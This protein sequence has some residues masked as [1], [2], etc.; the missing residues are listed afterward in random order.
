MSPELFPQ[1]RESLAGAALH[2]RAHPLR[3]LCEGDLKAL[4]YSELSLRIDGPFG[5]TTAN[6]G[7]HGQV[8]VDWPGSVQ[9]RFDVAIADAKEED[10]ANQ[11]SPP[12]R[13]GIVTKLWSPG[14]IHGIGPDLERVRQGTVSRRGSDFTGLV[15]VF[16]HPEVDWKVALRIY[17]PD[18]HIT[19]P[20][21]GIELIVVEP[22]GCHGALL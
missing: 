18:S 21:N 7:R 16:C 13:I 12:V 1:L 19:I 10:W 5:V 15:M 22:H 9:R 8:H 2:F 3:F 14:E 17:H 4:V 11:A 6:T 20:R